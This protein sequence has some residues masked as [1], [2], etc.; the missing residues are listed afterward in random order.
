MVAAVEDHRLVLLVAPH[1]LLTRPL[2]VAIDKNVEGLALIA[3]VGNGRHLRLQGDELVEAP[4][5]LLLRHI[6]G[7]VLGGIGARADASCMVYEL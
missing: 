1:E 4:Y 7:Q 2:A 6:V 5:F 3:T